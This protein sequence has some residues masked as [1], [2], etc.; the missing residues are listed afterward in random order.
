M[1]EIMKLEYKVGAIEFRAE[2]PVDAVEQQRINFMNTVLPAAVDAMVRTQSASVQ[3]RIID[4]PMQSDLLDEGK[5][6]NGADA[7]DLGIDFSR[8]SLASFLKPYGSLTDQDFTLFAA[9]FDELKNGNKAFSVENVRQY[10]QEGRRQADRDVQRRA[11]EL[12]E[13]LGRHPPLHQVRLHEGQQVLRQDEEGRHL[14]GPGGQIHLPGRVS[15]SPR[16]G[17]EEG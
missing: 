4:A 7:F 15:R 13:I 8:T 17:R 2:G 16:Q 3:E 5:Q 11:R 6:N 14:Q 9:Y 1:S 12:R 10:Y